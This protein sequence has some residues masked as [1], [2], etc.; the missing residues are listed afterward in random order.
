MRTLI[1]CQF[2]QN[3]HGPWSWT[4]ALAKYGTDLEARPHRSQLLLELR[5]AQLE[6]VKIYWKFDV[7]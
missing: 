4:K 6:G 2:T 3:K 1:K 7:F 5:G